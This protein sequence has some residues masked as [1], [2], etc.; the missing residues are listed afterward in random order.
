MR[1]ESDL[2]YSSSGSPYPGLDDRFK[3]NWGARFSGIIDVP[4]SGNWTFYLNTDDGSELWINGVSLI[5]NYGMHGMREYSG[6]INLSAGE[7]DFR[8]EFFQGGGP[9]GLRFS[10]E[11]PN[12]TKATIP[13]SAFYVHG[14]YV[15]QVDSLIHQW[16]F[17]EG[18]GNS[19]LDEVGSDT[20]LT[21]NGMNASNWKT[22]VDGNCLWFDG[23]DDYAKIDIDDWR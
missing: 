22:C 2:A 7:H 19:T 9:H 6:N 23:D 4:E 12:A 15:P 5:Q 20:N 8:I 10:W 16:N 18:S 11:G 21:L 14:D 1:I 17:E 3:N 13:A